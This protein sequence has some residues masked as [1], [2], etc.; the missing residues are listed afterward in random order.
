VFMY[1]RR[2]VISAATGAHSFQLC[3][4]KPGVRNIWRDK[5]V[6]CGCLPNINVKDG[7]FPKRLQVY[8]RTL[9]IA[10]PVDGKVTVSMTAVT[11]DLTVEL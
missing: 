11:E 10:A 5:T 9:E 4:L 2:S 6:D 3:I 7:D 8:G 1:S